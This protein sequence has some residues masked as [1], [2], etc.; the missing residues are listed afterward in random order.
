[1]LS[2]T[3][4]FLLGVGR[5]HHLKKPQDSQVCNGGEL[6][7]A[8][9]GHHATKFWTPPTPSYSEHGREEAVIINDNNHKCKGEEVAYWRKPK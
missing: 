2:S 5:E 4:T 6:P 9:N 3:Q 1:M 7:Q 8:L